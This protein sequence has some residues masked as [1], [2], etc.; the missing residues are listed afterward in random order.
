MLVPQGRVAFG[1]I[2]LAEDNIPCGPKASRYLRIANQDYQNLLPLLLRPLRLFFAPDSL[3]ACRIALLKATHWPLVA[4]IL[5][6]E[7]G[8]RAVDRR[9]GARGAGQPLTAS[10]SARPRSALMRRPLST[11]SVQTR[12]NIKASMSPPTGQLHIC[13]APHTEQQSKP[14]GRVQ[15][16]EALAASLR[17][18][19]QAID[20]LI[21]SEKSAELSA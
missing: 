17:E 4:L 6:Y 21:E 9:R 1:H 7:S 18:Q 16:L 19:L 11:R 5:A 2:A 14:Q 3:R 20:S 10:T 15:T 8:R 12:L 13:Q